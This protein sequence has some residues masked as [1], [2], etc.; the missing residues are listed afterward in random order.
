M[1][2]HKKLHNKTP[3][4]AAHFK[5]WIQLFTQTID[6]LF[7]GEKAELAKQRAISIAT[8]MQIKILHQQEKDS[9]I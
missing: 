5:E 7:E 9:G 6:E 2:V 8:M 3:L 4:N 1:M